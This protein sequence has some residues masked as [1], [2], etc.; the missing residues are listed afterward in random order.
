MQTLLVVWWRDAPQLL[1]NHSVSGP[2]HSSPARVFLSSNKVSSCPCMSRCQISC[3][4]SGL[5]LLVCTHHQSP[6]EACPRIMQ[7]LGA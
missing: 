4:N 2:Q 3:R 5:S 6:R 1:S 7:L